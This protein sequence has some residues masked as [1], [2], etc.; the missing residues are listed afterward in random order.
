MGTV[1]RHRGAIVTT[2]TLGFQNPVGEKSDYLLDVLLENSIG[3]TSGGA[4]FAWANRRG[5][6]LLLEDEI[7]VEFL[8]SAD[9]QLILGVD[10]VTTPDAL[11]S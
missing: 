10:Q 7:F 9:F 11:V 2:T 4:A 5:V 6:F 1:P 8:G 3:A